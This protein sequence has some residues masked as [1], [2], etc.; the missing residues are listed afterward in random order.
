MATETFTYALPRLQFLDALKG[1]YSL[2][3]FD[4][5][6][7]VLAGVLV[8]LTGNGV[9]L[10]ATDA[11]GLIEYDFRA[12]ES[13]AQDRTCDIILSASCVKDILKQ[14][15]STKWRSKAQPRRAFSFHVERSNSGVHAATLESEEETLALNLVDGVW[16]AYEAAIP[17]E[18]SAKPGL[19]WW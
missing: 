10:C 4:R 3:D 19:P 1:A 15:K 18:E 11:K 17:S 12:Q 8:R 9:I 2:R 5:T 14:F 16:P 6:S 13:S 7:A